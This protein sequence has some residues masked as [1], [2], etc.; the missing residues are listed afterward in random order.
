M[1][2]LLERR[3]PS[4]SNVSQVW[5]DATA[6]PGSCLVAALTRQVKGRQLVKG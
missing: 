5:A 4:A 6:C 2:G 3:E 1:I